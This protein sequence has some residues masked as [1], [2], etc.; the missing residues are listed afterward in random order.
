[1]DGDNRIFT[2]SNFDGQPWNWTQAVQVAGG[3]SSGPALTAFAGRP[4]L[5]W[6]GVP[7]DVRMFSASSSD[8]AAWTDL[9]QVG[10]GTSTG[11]ALVGFGGR[12]QLAWKGVPNDPRMFLASSPDSR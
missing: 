2:A 8:G 7:N 10:G 1:M 4:H 9:G 11:P 5:A 6:K 12:L 3:T